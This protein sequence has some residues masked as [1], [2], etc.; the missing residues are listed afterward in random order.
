MRYLMQHR[1]VNLLDKYDLNKDKVFMSGI[2]AL[3][4]LPIEQRRRDKINNINSAGFISGYRGSPLGGYDMQL[5]AAKKYLDEENI[6]FW[7]GLNEDLGA[8]AVWGSQALGLFSG[9]KYDG[10]FGIWYGKAP[11]VDRTGDVFKHANFAGTSKFGGALAIAGDDHNCKSST[12]PSQ[13]EFA[14]V[15]AE[16]PILNP[17]S[18]Q[19]V[20]DYG[21][22]GIAMSRF[23]GA[24]VGLIA[25]A[26]AMDSG[27]VINIDLDRIEIKTPNDFAFPQNGVSI[28][29]NDEPMA[30]EARLRHY[31]IPAAQAFVRENKLDRIT[32]EAKKRKIGIIASGQA[33]NDVLEAIDFMGLS[34]DDLAQY[35][36]SI[37]KI[38]MPWPLEPQ[39]IL[40]FAKGHETLLVVEHK[41]PLIE[42]QIKSILYDKEVEYRPNI[43]G[44][45]DAKGFTLLNEIATLQIHEIGRAILGLIENSPKYENANLALVR[46]KATLQNAYSLEGDSKRNPHFCSGCPHNSSTIVPE[47]SRALA[48]IGCHYMANF[49]P[50]RNTDMT[51]HMGGEGVTWIGQA[52]FTNETH[53][54]AN[55]GDGTYSHSGSLAIRAAVTSGVNITYKLLYNDA[56]AMTGGQSTESGQSVPQ[57]AKQLLGEGVA[58]VVIVTDDTK[59][60][61]FVRL[62]AGVRVFERHS[63]NFVQEELR[64]VKGVTIIIYDQ[65]CATEKRRRI[66]RGLMQSANTRVFINPM[67]CEGCGDCGAKSNCLSIHPVETEYGTKREIDQSSCNQD[68]RCID[69]FCPSFVSV[70][71]A[72]N[73]KR[74][75]PR[76]DF[77]ASLLP[78]PQMPN[79]EK[80]YSIVFTGVG[81]TGVTTV[82]AIIGM[83]A[84]IDGKNATT[85]DMTGLAQK[86]GQVLSH[87]RIAKNDVPIHSGRV[88]V[89]MADAAII[90]D[91]IVATNLDALKL[92]SKDTTNAVCN[93]DIAPSSEFIFDRNRKYQT[94]PKIE[95]FSKAVNEIDAINAEAIANEYLYDAMFANMV[96]LG[97]AWQKGMVP[98]S[99]RGIYRAIK[100]NGA[101]TI[102]NMLAFDLG[103]IAQYDP[104]R[105][106]EL[107]PPRKVPVR[108]TLDELIEHRMEFLN[109]Y[110]NQKLAKKYFDFVTK[111]RENEKLLLNGEA[112][113]YEIAENYFKLL[114]YKDEYE[115]ARLYSEPEYWN[116][117]RATLGGDIKIS[118][119]LAPPI[120]S[121]KDPVSGEPIKSKYGAWIF[122]VLKIMKNFKFLR[123]SIFDVFGYHP[124]RKSERF[125]IKQYETDILLACEK[126]KASNHLHAIELA[127]LPQEIRG[128][129][130]VKE[131]SVQKMQKIRD[132]LMAKLSN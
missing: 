129:G 45:R 85:L 17:S 20:L 23:C 62:E 112:F 26:D 65:M 119:W 80:P 36:V 66:K 60:Y 94:D 70:D 91:L 132:D 18:I 25:V 7:A 58:K 61:D 120:F 55:L 77:D 74:Q 101:A 122:P 13:S 27:A 46:A 75:R 76:P 130:H 34:F 73:A 59:K 68:T 118:L 16:I 83:A 117:L 99:L 78:L 126:L 125:L 100:L 8:T 114:A 28:R 29:R 128:Y 87:V 121:K 39:G 30:K 115:V 24:W 57:I 44:K 108:K 109:K 31:K 96:L 43:L 110:Q 4:R 102:D 50:N 47:G 97:F 32:C 88:P 81:G 107:V 82:S 79:I 40:D 11:G 90:G 12:L 123:G 92:V 41:R 10:V 69:G 104:Q 113:T 5:N 14:F 1:E 95:L 72:I 9:A 67:V 6:H 49:M 84:H 21:L 64:K 3:V 33:Y 2:H 93:S 105:L 42:N 116:N 22:Y 86:G 103:R 19:E 106:R 98:V 38:A 131:K 37:Y 111:I 35:G 124:E 63:L 71:G 54:F 127:S 53:I 48:G 51:S 52:P 56:V 89:S 15:D